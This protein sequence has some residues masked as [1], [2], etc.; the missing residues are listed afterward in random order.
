MISARLMAYYLLQMPGN[1]IVTDTECVVW[2]TVDVAP[3]AQEYAAGSWDS[4]ELDSS[5]VSQP[6]TV[7]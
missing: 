7:H 2:L 1:L 3:V 5:S 4:L 6:S